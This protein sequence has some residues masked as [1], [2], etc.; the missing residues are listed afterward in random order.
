MAH[1]VPNPPITFLTT[2]C[3]RCPGL[4]L[5]LSSVFQCYICQE[6]KQNKTKHLMTYINQSSYLPNIYGDSALCQEICLPRNAMVSKA[7]AVSLRV[8]ET[9]EFMRAST[10]EV[11]G[12]QE[13][14][15][16]GTWGHQVPGG[17]DLTIGNYLLNRRK[18][19]MFQKEITSR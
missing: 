1:A 18:R 15:K 2:P 17:D 5:H 13:A 19:R 14:H 7:D 11:Q 16:R 10:W 4:G 9:R 6:T 12:T 3:H 8:W